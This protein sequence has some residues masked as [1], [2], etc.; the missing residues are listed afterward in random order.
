M[1][2]A[3]SPAPT[4]IPA[5]ISTPISTPKEEWP[6]LDQQVLRSTRSHIRS[7]KVRFTCHWFRHQAGPN[8]CQGWTNGVDRLRGWAP[9]VA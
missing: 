8:C 1:S 4:P 2:P 3:Q 7:R 5:P 9:E 6:H